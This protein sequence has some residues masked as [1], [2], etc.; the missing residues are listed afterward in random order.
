MKILIIIALIASITYII[1]KHLQQLYTI[2]NYNVIKYYKSDKYKI[3]KIIKNVLDTN[4]IIHSND[5]NE[6]NVYLPSGYNNIEDDLKNI[7]IKNN[8]QKIFG[9]DGCDKIVSKNNLWNIIENTYGRN[10]AKILMPES[11][12]YDNNIHLD[13]FKKHYIKNKI[14]II[15]KNIQRKEGIILSNNYNQIITL[16]QDNYKI[17]QKYIENLYLI[18]NRKINLRIYLLIVRTNNIV[19]YY[20]HKKGKCIYTNKDY[21]LDNLDYE[22]HLTSLNVDNTIYNNRPQTFDELN[23]HL[24]SVNYK[25]LMDN[26]NKNLTLVLKACKPHVGILDK[27]KSNDTFQLFGLDYIFT[28]QMYPYLLEINKGPSM[29]SCNKTDEDQKYQVILDPIKMVDIIPNISN[30]FLNLNI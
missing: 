17:I 13:L 3:N 22:M 27:F 7:V 4:N 29:Y 15:K 28:S 12:T 18:H 19:S 1:Y 25:L 21:K 10:Q 30:E 6:W 26:I 20:I 16:K 2:S 5:I 14:Y 11:Y 23:C 24:G 9:I 8:K